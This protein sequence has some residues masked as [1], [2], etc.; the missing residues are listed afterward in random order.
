MTFHNQH[1][2]KR[3]CRLCGK[4]FTPTTPRN[5]R[6]SQCQSPR[7]AGC[8]NILSHISL[9]RLIKK[10]DRRCSDCWKAAITRPNGATQLDQSTGY[11]LE[12]SGG[13]WV[14]QHRLVVERHLGRKLGTD[15]HVH[16]VNGDKHD[17][18]I[19]NLEVLGLREHMEQ[20]HGDKL[21]APPRHRNGR[22]KKSDPTWRKDLMDA[23]KPLTKTR[24]PFG[25]A[26]RV[27]G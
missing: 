25:A 1:F 7:C 21:Y 18:R 23:C 12:K 14:L 20:R 27:M 5:K 22:R 9:A 19:E 10:R 13:E 16:H 4:C 8:G 26:A 17:N 15:E 6:C 11:I 24:C 2:S 3:T